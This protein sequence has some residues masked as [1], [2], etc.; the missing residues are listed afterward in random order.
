MVWGTASRILIPLGIL[1]ASLLA[2]WV[3]Q[4]LVSVKLRKTAQKPL[5]KW[6]DVLVQSLKGLVFVWFLLAGMA[7]ALKT[8]SLAPETQH[9]FH[10]FIFLTAIFS[11]FFKG[12]QQLSNLGLIRIHLEGFFPGFLGFRVMVQSEIAFAH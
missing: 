2:G 11:I 9:L 3:L 7:I 8:I 4:R 10:R 5:F 6:D 12:F 1:L